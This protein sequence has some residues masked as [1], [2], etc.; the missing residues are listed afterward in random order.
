VRAIAKA[1]LPRLRRL[2]LH[3]AHAT[4]ATFRE[5]GRSPTL[6]ALTA[7][8]VSENQDVVG[9]FGEPQ[10]PAL[11]ELVL[12]QTELDDQGLSAL[13]ASPLAA[14]LRVLDLSGNKLADTRPLLEATLPALRMLD[15]SKNPLAK[16]VREL[17]A[18]LPHVRVIGRAAPHQS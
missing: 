17:R 16:H 8:D 9:L 5:L 2:T 13:F 1:P 15:V 3:R 11:T 18:G 4:R 6:T 14:Q 12:R 7:L 10:L